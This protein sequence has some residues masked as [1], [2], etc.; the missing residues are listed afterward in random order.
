MKK[1]L[2]NTSSPKDLDLNKLLVI[3]RFRWE[4]TQVSIDRLVELAASNDSTGYYNYLRGFLKTE[5]QIRNL[6][7]VWVTSFKAIQEHVRGK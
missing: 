4:N 1:V 2:S 6:D 3:D 5:L 7:L